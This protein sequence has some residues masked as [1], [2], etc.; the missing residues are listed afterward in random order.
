MYSSTLAQLGQWQQEQERVIQRELE[1]AKRDLPLINAELQRLNT[2]R[3]TLEEYLRDPGLTVVERSEYNQILQ[4]MLQSITE[5]TERQR[6]L[7]NVRAVLTEQFKQQAAA[8]ITTSATQYQQRQAQERERGQ[9][10][11][12][13]SQQV[14]RGLGQRPGGLRASVLELLKRRKESHATR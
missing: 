13:F 10:R 2:D 4:T 12:A 3:A 11:R 7:S 5:L 14:Q 8:A 1:A 6:Q 9:A